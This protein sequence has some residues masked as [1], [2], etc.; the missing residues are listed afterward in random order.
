MAQ[1]PIFVNEKLKIGRPEHSL[2]PHSATFDNISFLP[3][4]P[5]PPPSAT[6]HLPL[7][8]RHLCM[9]PTI[10]EIFQNMYKVHLH[11][12]LQCREFLLHTLH[13][14]CFRAKAYSEPLQTS[15]KINLFACPVSS[16]LCAQ[17]DFNPL[18]AYPKELHL[19][20]L[21]RF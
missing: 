8:G 1:I 2:I 10:I 19:R 12:N 11:F 7:S 5:S 14:P 9:T 20:C 4:P 15:I 3:Y 13:L 18:T 16:I 17:L 6:H 21:K